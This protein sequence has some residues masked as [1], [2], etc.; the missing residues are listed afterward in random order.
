MVVSTRLTMAN[1]PAHYNELL[2]RWNQSPQFHRQCNYL[3]TIMFFFSTSTLAVINNIRSPHQ[4][5]VTTSVHWRWR[6]K[7]LHEPALVRGPPI[8]VGVPLTPSLRPHESRSNT[9][10]PRAP[11]PTQDY[12]LA[13]AHS[14]TTHFYVIFP[15]RATALSY[16]SW[17]P[18]QSHHLRLTK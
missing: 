1:L 16:N 3:I 9:G 7:W 2:H 18:R 14:Y 11:D 8:G 6:L 13:P 12:Y 15:P 4:D 10:L 5:P 17:G